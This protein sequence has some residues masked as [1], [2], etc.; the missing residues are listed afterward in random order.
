MQVLLMMLAVSKFCTSLHSCSLLTV[1]RMQRSCA[2]SGNACLD[3]ESIDEDQKEGD[4]V[5][6]AVAIPKGL[7][8]T[9][10]LLRARRCR[11]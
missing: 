7:Y 1:F 9:G 11:P 3:N 5:I 4:K 2:L 6:R 10:K 8:G